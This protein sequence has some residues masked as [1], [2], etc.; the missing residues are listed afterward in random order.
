MNECFWKHGQYGAL[1][2]LQGQQHFH[3]ETW[4]EI[5]DQEA[6]D[7]RRVFD[8]D[9]DYVLF[10]DMKGTGTTG[11]IT[12]EGF[13]QSGEHTRSGSYEVSD[14][15]V[16]MWLPAPLTQAEVDE[17]LASIRSTYK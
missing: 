10:V 16:I 9:G 2:H 1:G 17:A 15:D 12:W 8:Q 13:T 4:D 11:V 5:P 3:A 6:M 7:Q 14:P